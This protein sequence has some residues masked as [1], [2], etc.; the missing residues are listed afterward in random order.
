MMKKENV[1]V[2]LVSPEN[3]DNIGA[4]AR[5]VKNM[6]FADLRLV[7]PPKAWRTRAKKMA[8]SAEDILKKGKSTLRSKTRF[9]TSA[10]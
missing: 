3:T 1:A 6:G 9:R 5:A 2:I 4:A 10:L 7:E 8:V